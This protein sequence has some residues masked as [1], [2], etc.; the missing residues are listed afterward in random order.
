MVAH[1]LRGRGRRVH[2]ELEDSLVCI[3]RGG[4]MLEEKLGGRALSS[5]Q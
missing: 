4:E 5:Q 1:H 3:K 2:L